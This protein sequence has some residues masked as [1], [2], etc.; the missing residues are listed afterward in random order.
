MIKINIMHIRADVAEKIYDGNMT[1]KAAQK[2]ASKIIN[3]ELS[4][5]VYNY[6]LNY[7]K[8]NEF[9]DL[10]YND[11]NIKL[12]SF[13]EDSYICFDFEVTNEYLHEDDRRNIQQKLF[14]YL[15]GLEYDEG[16]CNSFNLHMRSYIL[17]IA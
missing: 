8:E 5:M 10:H 4:A 17:E 6:M 11:I 3:V 12:V 9:A 14:Y 2:K 13:I 7:C 1:Y 16:F 15:S